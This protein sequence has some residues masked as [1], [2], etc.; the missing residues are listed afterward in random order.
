MDYKFTHGFL[1]GCA[2]VG[3]LIWGLYFAGHLHIYGAGFTGLGRMV[4]LW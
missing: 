2:L 4:C 1:A 3:I